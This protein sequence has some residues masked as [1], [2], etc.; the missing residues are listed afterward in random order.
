[1]KPNLHAFLKDALQME[2]SAG[3]YQQSDHEDETE[4]LLQQNGFK[5]SF[6]NRFRML[7]RI[8]RKIR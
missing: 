5:K 8:F 2:F 7:L 3:G 1:M 6:F 4:N